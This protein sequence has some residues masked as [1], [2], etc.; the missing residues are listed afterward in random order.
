[1]EPVVE[2][3]C[4]GGLSPARGR[5]APLYAAGRI[6]PGL[7]Q[8]QEQAPKFGWSL[9]DGSFLRALKRA[10]EIRGLQSRGPV[11]DSR[12]IRL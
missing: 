10:L 9:G 4:S 1:M 2:R 12:T 11:F 6:T 7:C 8:I 5:E 3:K